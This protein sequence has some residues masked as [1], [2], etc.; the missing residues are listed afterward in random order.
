MLNR[1]LCLAL[2]GLA[3]PVLAAP[4]AAQSF[5]LPIEQLPPAARRSPG[6]W[7]T[8]AQP[9]GPIRFAFTPP[10]RRMFVERSGDIVLFPALFPAGVHFH[11]VAN[12]PK[13]FF[14]ERFQGAF[15]VWR[16]GDYYL[17][18]PA[19]YT[20]HSAT[21]RNGQL[22]AL[23]RDN[24]GYVVAISPTH[25]AITRIDGSP[26]R[27]QEAPSSPAKVSILVDRSA[28][29]SGYDNDIAAALATLSD[30]LVATE[31]CALYEFGIQVT[32]VQ[33][34]GSET[35]GSLFAR[36]RP[37][38]A[39]GGTPLHATMQQAYRDL[40]E[41]NALSAMVILS[42]GRPSDRPTSDLAELAASVPTFVLWVGSH[43]IDYIER[44]STAHAISSS[45]ARDEIQDFLLGIS[46]AV[47]GHQAFNIVDER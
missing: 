41:A 40:S 34:P 25:F 47:K 20:L 21:F 30:T 37:A 24:D 46:V 33:R 10:A 7:F 28:S 36:Y 1:I 35:C 16:V 19:G 5:G 4:A 15:G 23:V 44:Y 18:L 8:L 38:P 42:D 22:F 6:A 31:H 2:A 26:V 3:F 11:P 9:A 29:I 12:P 39:S 45:G 43:D 13:G 17:A 27:V 14:A 32:V